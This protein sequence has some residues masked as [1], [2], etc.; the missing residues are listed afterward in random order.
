MK[1]LLNL[2]FCLSALSLP[3]ANNA[4]LSR[5][6]EF[7]PAPGQFVNVLPEATADD[8]PQT[9]AAKAQAA[10]ADNTGSMIS[11]GGF[12]G[13]VVFGFDHPVVNVA[14]AYDLQILG[15]AVQNGAEP[16][17][18]SVSVDANHNGLPDD[19]WY[20]L[21]GSHYAS[22][23]T[24]HNYSVTYY[25]PA[26]SEDSVRWSDSEGHRGVMARNAFHTQDYY[27]LWYADSVSF[28]G[29]CLPAN[30]VDLSGTGASWSL[31]GFDW[32][33]V[34]NSPNI[35]NTPNFFDLDWAVNADG[36]P[37]PLAVIH[38]VR[39]HTGQHQQCGWLGETS[40]EITNAIDLHP[41]AVASL[42]TATFEDVAS[43]QFANGVNAWVSG[44]YNFYTYADISEWGTYY[45]AFVISDETDSVSS[46]YTE[47]LRSVAGGAFEGTRFAVWSSDFYGSNSLSLP[48]ADTVPGF[49]AVNNAYT[50]HEMRYGDFSRKFGSDDWLCLYCIGKLGGTVVDT[51]RFDLA[52]NDQYVGQWTYV[53]LSSLGQIDE[54]VFAMDGS[55]KG[56][57]GLNTPA[58]F[59]LDNF[60]AAK[61]EGYT[62]PAMLPLN[63]TA[64]DAAPTCPAPEVSKWISN[65]RLY[66]RS[67]GKVYDS[68][69][70]EVRE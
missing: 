45:Y 29:T 39:V 56:A 20:E 38:F 62:A 18:V 46:G 47:T 67:H 12:G 44:G 6:Y 37:H 64:I 4:Y 30:A 70:R 11:L 1:H 68:Q 43:T 69:G 3:A 22:S 41:D 35:L 66:I 21:A 26:Q 7:C 49:W 42:A 19:A 55:D 48:V 59:C 10:L 13:Y 61:P 5:V 57:W 28:S 2:V 23:E 25:R 36:T 52:R 51:V 31:P 65:G 14:D 53:D 54:L 27:P 50:L 17:I 40:T 9:M 24:L 8:T 60:G 34:D 16:G 33:Y 15:N 32:G 63:P 58:Y